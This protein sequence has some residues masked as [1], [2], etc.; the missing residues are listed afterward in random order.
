MGLDEYCHVECRRHLGRTVRIYHS[1]DKS[2]ARF[3]YDYMVWSQHVFC[4]IV[5]SLDDFVAGMSAFYS[6]LFYATAPPRAVG[7]KNATSVIYEGL[8]TLKF[9]VLGALLRLM[10]VS[11]GLF[12][13]SAERSVTAVLAL[14]A[15]AVVADGLFV[16]LGLKFKACAGGSA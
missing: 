15:F 10:T 2:M 3:F 12:W 4:S 8:K 16:E 11:T 9:P 14:V 5:G 1:F 7:I 6:G 13:V